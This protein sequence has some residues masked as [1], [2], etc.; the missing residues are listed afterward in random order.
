MLYPNKPWFPLRTERLVLREF[1]PADRDDAH[2]YASDPEVTRYMDWGPNDWATTVEVMDRW[3]KVQAEWPRADV[4]LAIVLPDTGRVIGSIR[5][6]V[7]DEPN[8]TGDFGYSLARDTWGLGDAT[9]AT[10]ALIDAGFGV[11]GL[12]RIWA[13]ADVRNTGSFRV[14]E[15]LG[16]R[17]EAR[18]RRDAC[19]RGEWRDTY[20]YAILRTEWDLSG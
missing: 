4:N 11:L 12:H 19:I 2:A 17:R 1:L 14:M 6:G 9:E 13:T 18:Y 10:R 8:R 7:K 20:R 15:K 5:L 3:A 16:M